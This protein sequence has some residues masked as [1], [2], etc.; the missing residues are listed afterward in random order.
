MRLSR[1]FLVTEK[2]LLTCWAVFCSLLFTDLPFINSDYLKHTL[3]TKL[4]S[5]DTFTSVHYYC[6]Q[7]LREHLYIYFYNI[8]VKCVVII[9]FFNKW[10]AK[11]W[12]IITKYPVLWR[13]LCELMR[14]CFSKA[15][16]SAR[17]DHF[18][19]NHSDKSFS[20]SLYQA[21]LSPLSGFWSL[22]YYW[23][24]L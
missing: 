10:K 1:L 20:Q 17:S 23:L 13:A 15:F 16:S 5:S 24:S 9:S 18:P 3:K 4:S 19:V 11:T 6:I 14:S 2:F 8:P 21:Y 7:E 12:D 22:P